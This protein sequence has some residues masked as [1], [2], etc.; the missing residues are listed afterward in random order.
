M[1]QRTLRARFFVLSCSFT[2]ALFAGCGGDDN[3]TI[4]TL[5][6][7]DGSLDN[8]GSAGD[9]SSRIDTVAATNRRGRAIRCRV[10][11]SPLAALTG[12]RHGMVLL[13]EE[14]GRAF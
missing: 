12:S 6:G 5:D 14:A 7:G 10:S 13:M 11:F 3:A 8:D 2:V 9:S 1:K 4:A